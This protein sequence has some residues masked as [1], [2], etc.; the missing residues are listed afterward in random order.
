MSF[1]VFMAI[2]FKVYGSHTSSGT[3]QHFSARK[4]N[5]KVW[6][7]PQRTMPENAMSGCR[8]ITSLQET[9]ISPKTDDSASVPLPF[10]GT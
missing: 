6:R 7:F 9:L 2:Y 8:C 3:T 4:Y 10:P 5:P 1:N